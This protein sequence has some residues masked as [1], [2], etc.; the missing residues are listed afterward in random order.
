MPK[1]TKTTTE[2]DFVVTI[3]A[4]QRMSQRFP[5]VASGVSDRQLGELIHAEVIDALDHG[6]S[7]KYAPLELAPTGRERWIA[8]K[9]GAHVAWNEDKRRGYVIQD[10]SEGLLV[11]TVLVGHER[12]EKRRRI[13]KS[14]LNK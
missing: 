3:H 8:M 12:E 11:L 14:G 4:L 10:S 1:Q 9:K 2:D 7:G 13:L 6:R 5:Q